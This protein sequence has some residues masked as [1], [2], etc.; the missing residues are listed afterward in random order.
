MAG[1]LIGGFVKMSD[2]MKDVNGKLQHFGVLLLLFVMGASIG[3]DHN[4][5]TQFK[6]LGLK[7]ALFALLTTAFSILLVYVLSKLILKGD[8]A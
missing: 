8:K 7:A 4:L 3:L 2:R 1:M 6:S 5:L